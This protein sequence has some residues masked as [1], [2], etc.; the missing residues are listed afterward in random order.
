MQ[1]QQAT[2]YDFPV[3][4]ERAF[5]MRGK[6]V[7]NTKLI[8]RKDTDL[9]LASVSDKY[10]LITHKEAMGPVSDFTRSLGASTVDYSLER[11][12]ARLLATHT[13]KD[14]AVTLPGHKMPGQ[15]QVGDTVA[16]RT[17]SI[18]SYNA[19]TSFEFSIGALVLRCLNGA[20]AFEDMFSLRYRHIGVDTLEFPKADLVLS[21]FQNQGNAWKAWAETEITPIQRT[22]LIEH[23]MKLQIVSK[24]AY[25]ENTEYFTGAETVWDLYNAATYVITHSTKIQE[26]GKLNRF[27]RLNILFNHTFS[28]KV[29]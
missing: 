7:P 5:D 2:S 24:R 14:I 23:T 29:A 25:S 3:D 21:A 9:V 17:H 11:D 18:N 16:L 8:V 15:K 28:K 6:V 10:R 27:D 13:Y 26:S 12:G 4:L 1:T 19:T 20:T 22:Q